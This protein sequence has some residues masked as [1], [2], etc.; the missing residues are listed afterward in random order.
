MQPTRTVYLG[1]ALVLLWAPAGAADRPEGPMAATP[2][3]ASA[4]HG[5]VAAAHPL[6][7][8]IGLRVLQDGGSAVDAAIATNAALGMLEPVACGAGGDRFAIVWDAKPGRLHGPNGSGR[9]AG[10]IRPEQVKPAADGPIPL[11][12]P[13]A[14]TVPGTVDA[15]FE[16]HKRFG[17]L[18]MARLLEPAIRAAEEGEPVPQVIAGS[19]SR[20]AE[21]LRE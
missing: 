15:W 8:Q 18:P 16:L 2:P 7:V 10:A 6:A 14:W 3:V 19:W 17:R 11:R 20:A 12:S 13:A 1:T 5:M 21:Q 9:P 4:R